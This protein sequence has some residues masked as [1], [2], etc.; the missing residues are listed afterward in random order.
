MGAGAWSV[1]EALFQ[2]SACPPQHVGIR[3]GA[4]YSVGRTMFETD[5]LTPEHARRCNAMDEVWV[6]TAFHKVS[7]GPKGMRVVCKNT[8]R[9]LR[10]VK[11]GIKLWVQRDVRGAKWALSRTANMPVIM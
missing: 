8:G 3:A 1:P 10:V 9:G 11:S 4:L 7:A 2:T 5:R 6:P